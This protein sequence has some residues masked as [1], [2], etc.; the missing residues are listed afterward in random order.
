MRGAMP[1]PMVPNNVSLSNMDGLAVKGTPGQLLLLTLASTIDDMDASMQQQCAALKAD[2]CKL[3]ERIPE[4]SSRKGNALM[5]LT[6]PADETAEEE[7]QRLVREIMDKSNTGRKEPQDDNLMP[8][9]WGK[10]NRDIWTEVKHAPN[11][12]ML[13]KTGFHVKR[14]YGPFDECYI[15]WKSSGT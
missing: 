11:A 7:A 5:L 2:A 8:D 9:Y 15:Q 1:R 13:Q 10:Y 4:P 6:P 3:G 12:A 14:E